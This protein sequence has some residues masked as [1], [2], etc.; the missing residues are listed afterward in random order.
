MVTEGDLKI[1]FE[2]KPLWEN[3]DFWKK[4]KEIKPK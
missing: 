2:R 4:W 3:L 1:I